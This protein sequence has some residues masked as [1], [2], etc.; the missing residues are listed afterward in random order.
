MSVSFA[1]GQSD[2]VTF[3]DLVRELLSKIGELINTQLELTKAEI[4]VE[5][6]KL[7]V[8][9]AMGAAALAIGFVFVLF[10][11]ISLILI[12]NQAMDLMWASLITSGFYLLITALLTVGTVFE[13]RRNSE[14]MKVD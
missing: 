9:V 13:I 2:K 5:G 4:R 7:L 14:R 3:S 6:R 1:P 8:A 10:F 12:L 11:G